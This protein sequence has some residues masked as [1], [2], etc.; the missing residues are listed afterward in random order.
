MTVEKGYKYRIYP[1]KQQAQVIAS[2]FGCT[3]CVYNYFRK[4]REDVYKRDGS[5]LGRFACS[6]Q[7]TVLKGVPGKEFLKDA[8]SMA[9]QE[10]IKDLDNAYQKFFRKEAGYPKFRSKHNPVQSYRTRNQ[11]NGVR[12]EDNNVRLPIVGWVKVKLSRSFNG[13]ILN[14]TVS[15]TATGKYFVSLCVREELVVG[16]NMG[17]TV[18]VDVG[19]KSF[20]I[21]SDGNKISNPKEYGKLEK[22]LAREQRKLS[23][24]KNGSNNRNKQRVRVARVHEQIANRRNDFLHKESRKLANENQVIAIESLNIKRMLRSHKFAKSVSDTSWSKF[25]GMLKYKSVETNSQVVEVDTYFASSQLCSC[26]GYKNDA[27][28]DLK[29]RKWTCPACGAVHD[30]DINAARN[31][32]NEGLRLLT[33]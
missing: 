10:A 8:D 19:I 12:I 30:R 27:V 9:L 17:G 22:K 15:R 21:D 20:Y 4:E 25:Y 31:I 2:I 7:L 26:C 14:A 33:N 16:S 28:K 1:T 32:L 3:R 5:T 24:K 13:K 23:R 18:G 6:N 11:G 29:V